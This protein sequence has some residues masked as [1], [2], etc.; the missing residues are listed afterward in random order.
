VTLHYEDEQIE[1][2]KLVVGPVDNNVFVLRD[3]AKHLA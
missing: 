2:H 3:K 1:I